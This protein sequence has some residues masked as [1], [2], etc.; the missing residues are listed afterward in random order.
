MTTAVPPATEYEALFVPALSRQ[1]APLIAD[2][3][4]IG[5][6]HRVLDVAVSTRAA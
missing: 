3:A 4:E 2:A 5:P 1:W 6:G